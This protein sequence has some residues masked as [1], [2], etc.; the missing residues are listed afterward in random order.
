MR[1]VMWPGRSRLD[2]GKPDQASKQER[3]RGRMYLCGTHYS[4]GCGHRRGCIRPARSELMWC[5][6]LVKLPAALAA[7]V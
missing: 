4:T 2:L 7:V 1:H 5:S 3:R 6:P